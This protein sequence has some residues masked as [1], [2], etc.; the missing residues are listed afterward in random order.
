MNDPSLNLKW[1]SLIFKDG[2]TQSELSLKDECALKHNF[3]YNNRLSKRDSFNWDLWVGNAWHAFQQTWRSTFGV[4][5]LTKHF[6]ESIPKNVPKGMAFEADYEYWSEILPVY[7]EQY[8]ALYTGEEVEPY[9][10]IEKVLKTE[11]LGFTLTGKIDLASS[12]YLFIRDFKTTVSAWLISPDGW[13]FKLQF[14]WYCWLM[15]QTFPEFFSKQPFDFQLDIMQKPAL[16]QTKQDG[17]LQ[18][19]IRRVKADI[20]MRPE[21]Y[22]T[23]ISKTIH[24][25]AI[26]HFEDTVLTP[27]IQQLALIRDNPEETLSLVTNPNTNVCNLYGN[28]CE[29]FE[30]CELGWNAGKFFFEHRKV[31][32]VEL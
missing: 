21:H 19:H 22:L 10:A 20:R 3:R 7:Q 14:M 24:Q 27:K 9:I 28:R 30:I 4:C 15:R 12:K 6:G 32:H 2:F 13:H 5:D 1:S 26:Q 18:G 31:K 25:P 8:A 17:T 16:K 23:R 29:F 11:Y